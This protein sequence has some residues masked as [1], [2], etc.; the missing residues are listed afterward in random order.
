MK[1]QLKKYRNRNQEV[2][3]TR[4]LNYLN[5]S[6]IEWYD[7]MIEFGITIAVVGILFINFDHW[8]YTRIKQNKLKENLK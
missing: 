2:P 6:D 8:L 1:Q 3:F 4:K 7:K 5:Q